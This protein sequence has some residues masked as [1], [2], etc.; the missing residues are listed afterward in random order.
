MQNSEFRIQNGS[1]CILTSAFCIRLLTVL[2]RAF[3]R[4]HR[5]QLGMR[6]FVILH[7]RFRASHRVRIAG[8]VNRVRLDE[9]LLIGRCG[10]EAVVDRCNR[11]G[12]DA[13]AAVDAFLGMNVEHRR[14][15]ELRFV[16]ARVDA[17][18]RTDVN[19]GGIFRADA[20]VGNNEGHGL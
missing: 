16:L 4:C 6:R 20:R 1:A 10:V 17:V 18:N 13:G 3:C 8:A 9:H 5:H 15:R 11:T 19:A 12:R 7:D 14:G 2:R